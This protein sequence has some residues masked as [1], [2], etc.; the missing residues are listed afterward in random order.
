MLLACLLTGTAAFQVGHMQAHSSAQQHRRMHSASVTMDDIPMVKPQD[1]NVV[2]SSRPN[3]KC[4][5]E[6]PKKGISEYGTVNM[7]FKPLLSTDSELILVRYALPFGLSAEPAGRVVRVT[8][9]GKGEGKERVGDILRFTLQWNNNQPAM[10][11]VC[12]CMER[13]LQN[14][15]DQV[16]Q[17]LVSNDGTYA[18]EIVLIFERPTT[19]E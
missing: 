18:E 8:K 11:D 13:Q 12:K 19:A 17:A 1:S 9:D 6:I 3:F 2:E 4:S 15:W 7:D 10:F 5:F 14:S 16:V